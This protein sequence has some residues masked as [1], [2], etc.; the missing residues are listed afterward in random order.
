MDF[1]FFAEGLTSS[2]EMALETRTTFLTEGL[3]TKALVNFVNGH[4]SFDCKT[5][6]F[7]ATP[8]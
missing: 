3:M 7:F 5:G 1:S 4:L 2:L 6:V 8:C